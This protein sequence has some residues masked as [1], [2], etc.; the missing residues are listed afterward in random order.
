MLGISAGRS[1]HVR[2]RGEIRL[3]KSDRGGEGGFS[4]DSVPPSATAVD[5]DLRMYPSGIR[6]ATGRCV[7]L[8]PGVVAPQA[9]VVRKALAAAFPAALCLVPVR[10]L[11]RWVAMVTRRGRIALVRPM[12]EDA[13]VVVVLVQVWE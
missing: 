2:W 7:D 12:A 10:P 4:L 6:V 8:G 13:Q 5:D 9:A 1:P 11:E 3:R